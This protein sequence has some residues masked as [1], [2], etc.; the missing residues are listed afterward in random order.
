MLRTL[1]RIDSAACCPNEYN[2][3]PNAADA[4]HT[5]IPLRMSLDSSATT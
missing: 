2:Q 1:S 3:A 4:R 5:N